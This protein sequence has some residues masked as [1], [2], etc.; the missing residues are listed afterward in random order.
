MTGWLLKAETEA[1]QKIIEANAQAEIQK[2]EADAY[3]YEVTAKAEAEAA[4][5]QKIAAS[6]TQSLIDYEY[7]QAWDGKYPTYYSG[8]SMIPVIN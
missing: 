1:E 2:V 6:L 3:A 4:A 7:A 5:N 8:D